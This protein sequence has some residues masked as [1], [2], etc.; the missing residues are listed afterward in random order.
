MHWIEH[1]ILIIPSGEEGKQSFLYF[2]SSF[3]GSV[4]WVIL[5]IT[6]YVKHRVAESESG[7]KVYLKKK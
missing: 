7:K 6:S 1:R 5:E 2:P 3:L 4:P